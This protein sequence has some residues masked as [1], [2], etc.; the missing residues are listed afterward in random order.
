MPS[1]HADE[2]PFVAA[3]GARGID[4]RPLV[5]GEAALA[6]DVDAYVVRTPWDWYH[7]PAE[8]DRFLA[9]LPEGRTFNAPSLM[10]RYLGKEY[11]ARLE[12]AV[13]T[14]LVEG[15][16]AEVRA[17]IARRG[18]PEAVVKPVL[19]ANAHRTVRV[20][21]GRPLAIELG[22]WLVQPFVAE[23]A[24]GELSFVFFDGIFS[25]VVR[26]RAAPG[27]FRVQV[28]HGGTVALEAADP[29]LV[30]QAA[31]VLGTLGAAPLYAR[32]DGV[33]VGGA[34]RVM[35]LEVVEPQL[36]FGLC[37]EAG[38]RLAAALARRLPR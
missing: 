1:L 35:E 11:L 13:P 10:R 6:A 20:G 25:H 22:R 5:W 37:A 38:P 31:R 24:G 36:F 33:V 16:A 28:E 19:S 15:G 32:V 2:A 18:W 21:A 27:D 12:G 8:F 9:A 30:A 3:L 34:L 26:K 7:A 17:A 29:A 23:V 14:E 4:A